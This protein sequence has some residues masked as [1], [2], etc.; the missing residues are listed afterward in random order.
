MLNTQ[1]TP[2]LM[3]FSLLGFNDF[4]K[5]ATLFEAVGE[6]SPRNDFAITYSNQKEKRDSE[7]FVTRAAMMD[8]R[9]LESLIDRTKQAGQ[10]ISTA[11]GEAFA[12]REKSGVDKG[13]LTKKGDWYVG[14]GAWR[15]NS[16]KAAKLGM[17]P[18]GLKY[19]DPK[20]DEILAQYFPETHAPSG[21]SISAD[22]ELQGFEPDEQEI[23]QEPV[24]Q[25]QEKELEPVMAESLKYIRLLEQA[26]DEFTLGPPKSVKRGVIVDPTTL[27][28]R[29][30]QN[31]D[32]E[33][34]D[35]V[36][37][38]GAPGI[39]KTEIVRKAAQE[40]S[41]RDKKDIPVMVITLATKAKYD[42][43]GLPLLFADK[44]S[45]S[46]P[47]DMKN[48][49]L[50]QEYRGKVGM[51]F[52]YPAWLP[53]ADDQ[54]D[55]ILFFD[56]INR[57]DP[58]VL[59]ACLTLMLDRVSGSYR[60]PNGWRIWA[61]GNRDVDGPVTKMEG[62]MASRFLG[63]HYHLVPTV[64]SWCD[65][66]RSEEA[67]FKGINKNIIEEWYIPEEFIGF[68]KLKDVR[69]ED[70]EAGDT[71]SLGKSFRTKFQ[72]FYNWDA[73]S[74]AEN[75][76]GKME[77]FPTPRTWARSFSTI[78][79]LIRKNPQAIQYAS[80][81]I[82]PRMKTM[83]AFGP[84]IYNDDAF[85]EDVMDVL[86]AIVGTEA[87]DPFIQF[88]RQMARYSEGGV[89][90]FEKIENV[91]K[92][93]KGSLP[94]IGLSDVTGDE[95]FGV[96]SLVEGKM[97]DLVLSE[98]MSSAELLN[99]MAYTTKLYDE[100]KIKQGELAGHVASCAEANREFFFKT[101]KKNNMEKDQNFSS[102]AGQAVIREW[103]SKFKGVLSKLQNI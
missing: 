9:E 88:V 62:A 13:A 91:F 1:K 26:D 34:R 82:D 33:T 51:D 47:D 5:K 65:W 72:F 100:Q 43:Q 74:A 23:E 97:K 45:S 75:S 80:D 36:M 41:K 38:W 42:I 69:R 86:A 76:G 85:M 2:T 44:G 73:A 3:N 102:P 58:E 70:K 29:L 10:A 61:A 39:G 7:G 22:G 56:E 68:L 31:F 71:V 52:A 101:L 77:G 64:D 53:P 78:F 32:L 59:G 67:Y 92:N 66:A 46:S 27:I 96:L 84:A 57:A 103:Q 15:I 35:N 24:S 50:P 20:Q 93:P 79:Q 89:N 90:L 14:E 83:S 37:I 19:F 30:I 60:I 6:K 99:W 17:V 16:A 48:M 8:P 4:I 49:V 21:T 55:G 25:S 18:A 87:A 98:Q 94:L 54:S 28:R 63:G 12:R 11:L 95:A 81:K 40:I